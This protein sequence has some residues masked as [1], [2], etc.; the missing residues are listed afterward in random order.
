MIRITAKNDGFRR[1]GI[2]HPKEPTEYPADRFDGEQLKALQ[3]EPNLIVEIIEKKTVATP[4]TPAEKVELIR[5]AK[6]IQ[7]LE[8][9]TKDEDRPEVLQAILARRQ[10]LNRPNAADT[11]KAV[12]AVKT[13]DALDVLA[14]DE[15]RDSVTK[16]IT[17]RREELTTPAKDAD[18]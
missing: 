3:S 13:V 16:A 5:S 9:L 4:Q 12:K 11:I 7:A 10:I 2:G 1:A 15:D 14:K 8:K 6:N 18:K 17:K